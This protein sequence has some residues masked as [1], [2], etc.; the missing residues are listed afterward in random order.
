[1]KSANN[2]EYLRGGTIMKITK[3]IKKFA[4]KLFSKLVI[5]WLIILF[6]IGWVIM[7][8]YHASER[9][10]IFNMCLNIVAVA[11]ALYVVNRDM[12]P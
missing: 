11:F 4:S 2:I 9:N 1:M 12:K 5:M 3:Y 7:L 6:Q 8:V 10:S